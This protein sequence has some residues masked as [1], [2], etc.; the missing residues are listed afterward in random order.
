MLNAETPV[1]LRSFFKI[2]K[3]AVALIELPPVA[4]TENVKAPAGVDPSSA[5]VN[6]EFD[7]LLA[8]LGKLIEVGLN[9]EV[10][11]VGKPVTDKIAEFGV[12]DVLV[13]VTE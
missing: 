13:T 11:P 7:E 5:S 6:C 9:D 2:F 1:M 4:T 12:P 8:P 10:T 3:V